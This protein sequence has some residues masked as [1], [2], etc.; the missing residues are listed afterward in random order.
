MYTGKYKDRP[1]VDVECSALI[2][3]VLWKVANGQPFV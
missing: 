1:A 3:S 2:T